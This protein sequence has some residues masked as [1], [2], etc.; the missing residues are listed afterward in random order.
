[1]ETKKKTTRREIDPGAAT[2]A[3]GI[4]GHELDGELL[5]GSG[6]AEEDLLRA[7][8]CGLQRMEYPKPP[9]DYLASI[10]KAVESRRMPWWYRA[11]RWA[12][13]PHPVTIT[14]LRVVPAAAALLVCL[15]SAGYVFR[16]GTGQLPPS[17]SE[18]GIPVTFTL[19]MPDARSVHVVGSFN[20]WHPHRGEMR[21]S[22]EA[23]WTI[24][25]RLPEG[26]HEYAF[27]VDGTRVV[28]DPHSEFYQDDGFGNQNNI[29]VV[30]NT[31]ETAI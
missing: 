8:S 3:A 1:M 22:D 26:R 24:M 9:A 18:K 13:S 25:L 4:S 12:K 28:P 29:L 15:L 2:D 20:R 30:G 23:T 11:Y 21:K 16:G 7:V 17:G 31:H 6:S 10:M 5:T 19:K 14:P 27:L